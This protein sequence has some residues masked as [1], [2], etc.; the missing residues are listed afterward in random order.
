[1]AA[2]SIAKP[3][4][5]ESETI[6]ELRDRCAKLETELSDL[7][8]KRYASKRRP[9]AKIYCVT[10]EKKNNSIPASKALRFVND[11]MI[12]IKDGVIQGVTCITE[13]GDDRELFIHRIG[14]HSVDKDRAI[15]ALFRCAVGVT[16]ERER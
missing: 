8:A 10:P 9:S 16:M 1:M 6:R 3:S 14:S 13:E 15:S 4:E 5:S 2:H 11:M 7:T 12:G